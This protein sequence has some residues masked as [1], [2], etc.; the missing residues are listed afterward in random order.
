MRVR[1]FRLEVFAVLLS[2][3]AGEIDRWRDSVWFWASGA[4]MRFFSV[5]RPVTVMATSSPGWR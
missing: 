5:D 1:P 3:K 2:W 4:A